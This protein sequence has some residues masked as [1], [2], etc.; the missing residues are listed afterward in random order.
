MRLAET[1]FWFVGISDK[2]TGKVS[3]PGIDAGAFSAFA[4]QGASEPKERGQLLRHP[5]PNQISGEDGSACS[6]V[7]SSP[8]PE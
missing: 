6:P 5:R 2:D 7:P 3:L 4:E 1:L 8:G